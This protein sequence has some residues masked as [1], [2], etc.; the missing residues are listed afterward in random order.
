[1]PA[2]TEPFHAAAR[3]KPL[4]AV[5]IL[6]ASAVG[7]IG[8]IWWGLHEKPSPLDTPSQTPSNDQPAAGIVQPMESASAE[9]REFHEV[10][11]SGAAIATPAE[12]KVLEVPPEK[13]KYEG[14]SLPRSSE[15]LKIPWCNPKQK[16]L[17]ASDLAQLDDLIHELNI[18]LERAK[19]KL[20]SRRHELGVALAKAGQYTVQAP[21]EV[22]AIMTAPGVAQMDVII[23]GAGPVR[24]L[25]EYG[26]DA[27]CVQLNQDLEAFYSSGMD[28]IHEFIA[29][30]GS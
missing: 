11:G 12:Q 17:T 28:V 21:V 1:M 5:S 20:M 8:L 4:L 6:A 15:C 22:A 9:R 24:V 3:S 29:V 23:G 2:P 25:V 7:V 27:V 30:N 10:D 26:N 18:D 14:Q 16:S 13:P 19:A